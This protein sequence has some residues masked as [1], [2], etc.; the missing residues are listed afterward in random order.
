MTHEEV[1]T[2]KNQAIEV[3]AADAASIENKEE[4]VAAFREANIALVGLWDARGYDLSDPDQRG[5][6]RASVQLGDELAGRS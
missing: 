5:L 3:F 6:Y 2:L 4:L 1:P